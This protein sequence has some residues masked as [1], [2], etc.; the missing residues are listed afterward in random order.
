M[1][2]PN[3]SIIIVL[4]IS[5]ALGFIVGCENDAQ[6]GA[7]LGAAL[8]TGVAAIAGGDSK[9]LMIGA[10]VGTGAGY[11]L[12]NESDKKKAEAA[13]YNDNEF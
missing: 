2:R 11:I 6:N 4:I 8:G 7:L 9:A 1:L 5:S 13:K 3:K 10:G 12:G